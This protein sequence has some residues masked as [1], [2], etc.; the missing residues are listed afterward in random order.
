MLR[1]GGKVAKGGGRL[2]RERLIMRAGGRGLEARRTLKQAG[3]PHSQVRKVADAKYEANLLPE[4]AVL[5][6]DQCK[7]ARGAHNST[8]QT[9][10][11]VAPQRRPLCAPRAPTKP[12][13]A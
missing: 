11:P 10:Q 2:P 3:T 5:R 13:T 6:L 12:L 8:R 4:K 7:R 9:H 1:G